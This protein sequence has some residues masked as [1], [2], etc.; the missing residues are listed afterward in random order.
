MG[1]SAH[2][3]PMKAIVLF[4]VGGSLYVAL[5]YFW[6]GFS[7]VSMFIT[8][9]VA[10]VL[11]NGL[12]TRFATLPLAALGAISA[13]VVTAL[14]F[15]VGALVN[16]RLGLRVWDYSGVRWNLYGQVCL[17][18]SLL[19]FGLCVPVVAVLQLVNAI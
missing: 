17:G 19:W 10:L 1:L 11:L 14:E 12:A 13:V 6:R 18:Y 9:G 16:V 7:H 5:E 8:G 4:L 3:M 15:V 2:T